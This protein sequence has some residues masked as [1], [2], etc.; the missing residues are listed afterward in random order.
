MVSDHVTDCE[1]DDLVND[2]WTDE[3][4]D[5]W[6]DIDLDNDDWD[7]EDESTDL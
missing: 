4:E 5:V 1:D 2:A 3:D 6:E 7:D